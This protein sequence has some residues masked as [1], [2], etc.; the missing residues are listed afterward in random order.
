M[1]IYNTGTKSNPATNLLNNAIVQPT[2]IAQPYSGTKSSYTGGSIVDYLSSTGQDSSFSSRSKLAQQYGISGYQGTATQNTQLLNILR[3]SP[4][5]TL[6]TPTGTKQTVA[7]GSQQA[8]D[9][10]K[11]G[12]NITPPVDTSKVSSSV[13]SPTTQTNLPEQ[14]AQ[15]ATAQA[16][17]ARA[18]IAEDIKAYEKLLTPQETE[19]SKAYEKLLQE[20]Q[21]ESDTLTGRGTAQLAAEE[22]RGIPGMQQAIG[23][24]VTELNK[25]MAE[26]DALTSAYNSEN[27]KL[28]GMNILS[29][30][31]AGKK[32]QLYRQYV[33]QKNLLTSEAGIVQAQLLGMQGNLASAQEAAN[34]AVDLQYAD[35]ESSYNAKLERLNL[36]LPQLEKEEK[37]YADALS[38]VLE[39]QKADLETE[40][41][42]K[43]DI[44]SVHLEAIKNGVTDASILNRIRNAKNVGEAQQ[45]LGENIPQQTTSLDDV[46]KSLQIQKLQQEL[47]NP[48]GD[49]MTNDYKNWL[50]AGGQEG[51]GQSFGDYSVKPSE[52]KQY[53]FTSANFASRISQANDIFDSIGS[54]FTGIK[55]IIG[56]KLPNI[57]KSSDRQAFEQAERNYIN[58]VLRRES[59]AVISDAEFDNARKQY[60]PQPGDTEKTLKQKSANRNLVEQNLIKESGNAIDPSIQLKSIIRLNPNLRGMI[61]KAQSDGRTPDEIIQILGFSQVGNTTA[62]NIKLGSRLAKVNNNPGNLR[63][64]G[65]AG[66]SQG[67]GGFARF[68]TPQAG[69]EALKNQIKLDASRGHTL[70][71]FIAKYAPPT[72]NATNQYIQQISSRLGVSPKTKVSSVDLEKLAR[73]MAKKESSTII[74]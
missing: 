5:A 11:S 73:E 41:Q 31:I 12:A 69:Y 70:E 64:V 72:E 21:T 19:T 46:Y 18:S 58:S 59:G 71:S 32:G 17:T 52:P 9:L 68:S 29:S 15:I 1:A 47:D 38:L 33:A 30:G 61:E 66:A 20:L 42:E 40:K 16:D 51:T 35:R 14:P 63:F 7:V 48:V 53:Q 67:E 49:I 57:L 23:N 43:K 8:N 37:R 34:R 22:A 50:L 25:K 62:S 55:S 28:E 60:I 56:A 4:T 13:L 74:T 3:G 10:L 27:T 39:Q 26:I 45:I 44:L 6:T 2:T 54:K 65:Q 24:T 36:L